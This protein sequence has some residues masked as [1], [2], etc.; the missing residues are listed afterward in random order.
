MSKS[1]RFRY[2]A[3]LSPRE[4]IRRLLAGV[5]MSVVSALVLLIGLGDPSYGVVFIVVGGIGVLF[6][7]PVTIYAL[8]G[9]ISLR[10]RP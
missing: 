9:I 8:V 4:R 10:Q 5:I 2:I 3:F 1:S 7:A 6:F